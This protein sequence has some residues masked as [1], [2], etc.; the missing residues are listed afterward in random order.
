MIIIIIIIIIKSERE[1]ERKK[2]TEKGF[3]T[4]APAS[5]SHLPQ[6]EEGELP[7]PYSDVRRFCS[8][9]RWLL[10]GKKSAQE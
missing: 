9:L 6:E 2:Y 3:H 1:R 7:H 8:S 5:D 10:L 4:C